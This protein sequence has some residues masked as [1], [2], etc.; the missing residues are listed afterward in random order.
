L[1]AL[2]TNLAAVATRRQSAGAWPRNEETLLLLSGSTSTIA[3]PGGRRATIR[4]AKRESLDQVEPDIN[5]KIADV[6][7]V[8]KF[9]NARRGST[10]ARST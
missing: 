6:G 2:N 5:R 9:F 1:K 8:E 7:S 4:D 3:T 10:L